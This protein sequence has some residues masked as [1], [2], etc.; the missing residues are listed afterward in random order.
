MLP[1][2]AVKP[3]KATST[4]QNTKI[5]V[6]HTLQPNRPLF[7]GNENEMLPIDEV[8][9]RLDKDGPFADGVGYK[10]VKVIHGT[11]Y[12]DCST[13][14]IVPSRD[15]R[16]HW[17]VVQSWEGLMQPMNQK[18]AKLFCVNEEVGHAYDS[19]IRDVILAHPDLSKWKYVMTLETDNLIPP[20]AH[21]RLLESIEEFKLDAVGAIYFTKGDHS[22]PMAYGDPD[23]YAKTGVLDFTP[24]DIRPFIGTGRHV[25]PVNGIAMGCSLYRMELLKKMAAANKRMFETVADVTPQGPM[26][27]TQDLKFCREAITQFGAKFGV[28]LRV[29]VGHLDLSSGR[30]W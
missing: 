10:Q 29:K 7:M 1:C 28:D 25:M 18:R 15:D 12:R 8:A 4:I 13:I 27:F 17:R 5:G 11:H 3:K 21:I 19:M 20:D 30:V 24:R 9:Q 22:M 26:A 16:I 6:T 14:I 2:I 23:Q